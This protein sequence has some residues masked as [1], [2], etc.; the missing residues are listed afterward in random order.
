MEFNWR[1]KCDSPTYNNSS[2]HAPQLLLLHHACGP[3]CKSHVHLIDFP[4]SRICFIITIS[5]TNKS[6]C[7]DESTRQ[8]W[9]HCR[10]WFLSLQLLSFR[11]C[12]L[13][14]Q[15]LCARTN[16]GFRWADSLIDGFW[17]GNN[18]VFACDF[19][20][21]K[22]FLR[23]R[24]HT[25][26]VEAVS[27][28]VMITESIGTMRIDETKGQ[29]VKQ[30]RWQFSSRQRLIFRWRFSNQL[31]LPPQLKPWFFREQ[32][33]CWLGNHHR[34]LSSCRLRNHQR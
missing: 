16:P 23:S 13:S 18:S 32:S 15:K 14:Q 33:P 22:V 20:V 21:N 17:V 1:Y 19:G 34:K 6:L 9:K 29:L 3:S 25:S 10:W 7:P 31:G 8:T 24:I 4:H 30:C 2:T 12:I 28:S 11:R 27:F 26:V 5:T